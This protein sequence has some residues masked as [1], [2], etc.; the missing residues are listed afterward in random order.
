MGYDM[1]PKNEGQKYFH[2]GAFLWPH[3]L[4]QCGAYFLCLNKGPKYY[5][6][7]GIDERMPQ[8]DT[9]PAL[10]SNGGF[11]VTEEE[12][13]VLARIARNYAVIQ[14]HLPEQPE[15]DDALFKPEFMQPWPRKVR[16]DWVDTLEAF[17]SWAEKSGGFEIY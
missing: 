9:Y 3:F 14:R 12:A 4:E 11:P 15:D 7:T 2:M 13:K 16:D 17:A 8:G 10:I 6:V 5:Y 1:K